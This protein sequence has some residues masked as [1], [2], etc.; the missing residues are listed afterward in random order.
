MQNLYNNHEVTSVAHFKL[1][2]SGQGPVCIQVI[3]HRGTVKTLPPKILGIQII[4]Q[5]GSTVY[6]RMAMGGSAL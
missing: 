4:T 3:P 6:I 2:F 1:C 5:Y